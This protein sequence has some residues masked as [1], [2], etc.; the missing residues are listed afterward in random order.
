MIEDLLKKAGMSPKRIRY[1]AWAVDFIFYVIFFAV[2]LNAY[3][4]A[5]V[6]CLQSIYEIK[7]H[8]AITCSNS[9][10]PDL[11]YTVNSSFSQNINW[12]NYSLE[13]G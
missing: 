4:Y 8:C 7:T 10:I 9:S 6:Y 3:N 11:P 1:V 13:G 12:V 2:I 5:N